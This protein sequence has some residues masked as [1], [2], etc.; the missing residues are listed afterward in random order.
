LSPIGGSASAGG[1]SAWRG[2]EHHGRSGVR[3]LVVVFVVLFLGVTG[4][5]VLGAVVKA[6]T[7]PKSVCPVHQECANPPRRVRLLSGP[8]LTGA[9]LTG[10]KVFVSPGLGY[11]LEYPNG[12]AIDSHTPMG[13]E[14]GPTSGSSFIVLLKGASARQATPPQLL[15][16]IL[17]DLHSSI[18]DLQADPDPSTEILSPALAGHAGVGGLYQGDVDSPSGLVSPVDVAVLASSNGQQTLATAV[19]STNRSQTNNFLIF[20]DQAVLDTLRFKADIPR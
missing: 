11:Q 7:A 18:P 3:R 17:N 19:I 13:V 8:S 12:I 1:R 20:I 16:A 10:N 9:L 2:G 15:A 6:P 5:A 14:L 4:L